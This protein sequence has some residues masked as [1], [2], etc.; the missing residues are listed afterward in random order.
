MKGYAYVPVHVYLYVRVH[1]SGRVCYVQYASDRPVNGA[2]RTI[3][4]NQNKKIRDAH[5]NRKIENKK[6]NPVAVPAR[7][8]R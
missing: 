5:E 7:A 4:A 8:G 2:M 1:S 6:I 3:T